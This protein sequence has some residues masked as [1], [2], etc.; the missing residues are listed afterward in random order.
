MALILLV[1]DEESIVEFVS[2]NLRKYGHEVEVARTGGEALA[3][4]AVRSFELVI[5]DIML[6]D[7]DV[8]EVLKDVRVKGNTPI[9]ML[10]ALDDATDKVLGLEL[11]ADDYMAKP[12]DVR[13]LISRIKA[14]LRRSS[15][16]PQARVLTVHE[17]RIDRD[18]RV[19]NVNGREVDLTTMEFDLLQCL[20][21]NAGLVLSRQTLIEKVWKNA[22]SGERTVDSHVKSLRKKLGQAGARESI[23]TIR[24]IGYRLKEQI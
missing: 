6:P 19:C 9:L 14:I 5:L 4:L 10:S 23:E 8:F 22:P 11:G 13:E 1:D 18:R 15:G 7:I 24:G 17:L 12:F 20:M 21:M 2:Y 16:E 3:A